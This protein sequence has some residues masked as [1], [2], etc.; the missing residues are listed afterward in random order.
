LTNSSAVCAIAN[1]GMNNAA[2]A[3]I[4]VSFIAI[5]SLDRL[6]ERIIAPAAFSIDRTKRPKKLFR[7]PQPSGRGS[8]DLCADRD[9][10]GFIRPREH[11]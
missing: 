2:V 3:T 8:W 4:V 1:P 7:A 9:H 6:F 11:V 5:S 10:C